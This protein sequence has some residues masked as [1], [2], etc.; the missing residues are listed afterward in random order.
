MNGCSRLRA[1]RLSVVVIVAAAVFGLLSGSAAGSA[2]PENSP[3]RPPAFPP[4]L[5]STV[6]KLP[7]GPRPPGAFSIQATPLN[8]T[9]RWSDDSTDEQKFVV[10]RRDEHAN[11]QA[12]FQ[13]P[14]RN[15]AAR[16]GDYTYVDNGHS[17]S[18]QCYVVAA[19]NQNGAG[20]TDEHCTVRPDA[21]RFPQSVP[22]AAKQWSGLSNV[23][24]G[25]GA[26]RNSALKRTEGT[27]LHYQRRTFG[28]NLGWTSPNHSLW[29]IEA[30]GGPHL[31]Y[32]QAVA[33]RVW[34]GGWVKYG[35]RTWSINLVWSST[36]SY[37]WYILGGVPGDTPDGQDFALWNSV[38]K[39]YVVFHT[40]TPGVDLAWY[41][42]TVPPSTAGT[43]HAATVTMTAQPPVEGYVPFLG[44]FGGGPGNTSILTKVSNPPGGP[45]LRF[46]KPG[47]GS[48][49]CGNAS[50][51]ILLTPGETMQA[52]DMQA[53]WGSK[54]PSLSQELPFLTCAATQASRVFVNVE[55]RE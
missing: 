34:G 26:L 47:H 20:Y 27:A 45:T 19:V 43:V 50:A 31:M 52:K 39:D 16:D 35:R 14:T 17:I 25:T 40:R 6:A 24:D 13:A 55:Y 51:V 54:T 28:I 53:L 4:S 9:I 23:N 36:P 41:S 7:S 37:E 11:W 33:L 21:S 1:A 22:K 5:P 46:L 44:Y 32:G 12:I 15:A 2:A 30:E 8:V 29:K 49:D 38:A 42:D 3:P 48:Q 10:Y 18:G